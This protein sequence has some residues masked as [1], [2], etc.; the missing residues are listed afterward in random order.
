VTSVVWA[1]IKRPVVELAKS[2][3]QARRPNN[4]TTVQHRS[5]MCVE[6]QPLLADFYP[7]RGPV[8]GG[9][10]LTLAGFH[11]DAGAEAKLTLSDAADEMRS[12][13]CVFA[14][15]WSSNDSSCLTASSSRPFN[16]STIH[17]TIDGN[18]V[19]HTVPPHGYSM[20]PDPTIHTI[21]PQE[22]IVR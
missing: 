8:S 19:P 11:L 14:D 16:A 2:R 15:R 18:V 22:T 12:F 9:T 5:C 13:S 6:Q 17:F 1:Q 21:V 10:K 4:Y 20:L 7:V 3:S